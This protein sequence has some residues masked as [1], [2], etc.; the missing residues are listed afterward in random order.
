VSGPA[1][2]PLR[3][4]DYALIGDTHTAALVGRDGSIDWLCLP[5]FDSGACFA[6]LLGNAD[7]GRWLIAPAE[8]I[9]TTRRQYRGDTLVLETEFETDGGAVRV[10]DFMTPRDQEPDLIRIV[11]GCRG[12]VRMRSELI[13]RFDYGWVVPW[14][15]RA[16]EH[17]SY[18]AGPDALSLW[19]PAPMH[20]ADFTTRAEFAVRAGERIPFLLMWYPSHTKAPPPFDTNAALTETVRWW[21][22]WARRCS[23][24]GPWRATVVRSL[25]TLKALT[26][27]P[28]GGI[29]AAPTTSLPEQ[30]GGV[31]NWDY[32]YCWLRDATFTLYAL[33]MAGYTD[34]A[35]AWRNWLLRAAAGV[36][37]S[38][39]MVYGMRGERRLTEL[40]LPWLSGYEGSQP[41]RV[42]NSASEQLQLDV[43]GEIMHA[44]HVARRIGLEVEAAA[45]A[46]QRALMEYLESA[47][48]EP[49]EGIWEVRGPRRQFTHSKVMAWVAFDRSV[50]AVEQFGVDGPADRWR[51]LRDEVHA[52]V[53][54]AGYD[55]ERNTFTQFYGSRELDASLLMIPLVGFLPP[56]D[57]RVSGTVLAIERELM[58]RGF[59]RRYRPRQHIDGLPGGEGAFLACTFWLADNY[60]LQ[61]EHDKARRLFERVLAICND[62]GLLAEEFEPESARHLGNFPQAFSH[63]ALVNS[64]HNLARTRG[65]AEQRRD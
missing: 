58:W 19:T 15:R 43:Y 61:G 32:R 48:R 9:R 22:Q 2:M 57:P 27:A 51:Q 60:A 16:D 12:E 42:G 20:G 40:E 30:I 52:E 7:H 3:I 5:T 55:A 50:K 6:A 13:V 17:L 62:V 38:L 64:A 41:V 65:P 59:V 1:A 45:W 11:E 39:Q 35:A 28:T 21:E 53:C 36:P 54:R 29:V 47:W 44:L 33:M 23:Y 18:V 63:V 24:E 31:R 34:E 25:I 14:V 56:E 46:L 4:E 10:I 37:S 49:D 26:Y 8:D